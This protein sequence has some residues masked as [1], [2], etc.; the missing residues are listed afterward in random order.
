MNKK[1]IWTI[2]IIAIIA[3]VAIV[4]GL[5]GGNQSVTGSG[6]TGEGF[7]NYTSLGLDKWFSLNG[8]DSIVKAGSLTTATGTIAYEANPFSATSTVD[9]M[10]INVTS[11]TAASVAAITYTCGTTTVLGA[12]PSATLISSGAVATGTTV[13]LTNGVGY[14]ANL[15]TVGNGNKCINVGPSEIVSCFITTASSSA[16]NAGIAGTYKMHWVR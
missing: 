13:Y 6:T 15:G 12:A 1:L 16:A 8:L 3:V 10:S 11:A 9:F 2:G 4:I 5:V 14:T 7:T